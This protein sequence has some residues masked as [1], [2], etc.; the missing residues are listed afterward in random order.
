MSEMKIDLSQY[1]NALSRKH[2]LIR[3]L[4]SVVWIL[5]A[6][7]LPCSVECGWKRF[8]LHL[9]GIKID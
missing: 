8:L 7:W 2:Q 5:G 3:A 1:H 4:W 9:F 6:R